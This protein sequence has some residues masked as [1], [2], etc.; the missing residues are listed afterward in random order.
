MLSPRL[1]VLLSLC[2][3]D[4]CL[5]DVG[6]DHGQLPLHAVASGRVQRAIGI[7]RRPH[8]VEAARRRAHRDGYAERVSFR[9]GSGLEPLVPG[10]VPVVVFAGLGGINVLRCLEGRPDVLA[11]TQALVLQPNRDLPRVRR[12]LYERGWSIDAEALPRE[13]SRH[14]PTVRA[15]PVAAPRPTELELWVGP[16]ILSADYPEVGAYLALLLGDLERRARSLGPGGQLA[17]RLSEQLRTRV[18]DRERSAH[19]ET[20]STDP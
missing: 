6:C 19:R 17:R 11:R 4:R 18:E 12:W 1:Q 16:R 15:V 20:E 7:D 9:I 10:E 13:G 14:F 2:S 3:S 8:L 5:A